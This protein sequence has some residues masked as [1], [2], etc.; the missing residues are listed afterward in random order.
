MK[1]G[2]TST[3]ARKAAWALSLALS[4]CH[5]PCSAQPF[6]KGVLQT[7][8]GYR[9]DIAGGSLDLFYFAAQNP[10]NLFRTIKP[11]LRRRTA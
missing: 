7:P 6:G 11:P 4:L 2:S 1:A 10:A 3:V 8:V 5:V 9:W